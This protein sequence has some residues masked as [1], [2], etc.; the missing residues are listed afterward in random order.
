MKNK[1]TTKSVIFM[2]WIIIT[3]TYLLTLAFSHILYRLLF[4]TPADHN[5]NSSGTFI[6][7]FMLTVPYIVGGLFVR[8]TTIKPIITA[9]WISIV[10]TLSEKS[11]LLWIGAAFVNIEPV[12]GATTSITFLR[13]DGG[14][15]F[16]TVPYM[17]LSVLSIFICIF[18]AAY[19]KSNFA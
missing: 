7:L 5:W 14:L 12:I 19:K 8:K 1:T 17:V 9:F 3:M 16:F 18:V 6:G 2:G 15:P 13:G 10:P 4:Q 11:L